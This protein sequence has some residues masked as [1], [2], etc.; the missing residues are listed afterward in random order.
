VASQR[1]VGA[2]HR[3]VAALREAG[4]R[5]RK[6][7][8]PAPALLDRGS[9]GKVKAMAISMFKAHALQVMDKEYSL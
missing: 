1:K 8:F 2:V 7:G 9:R 6:N 5:I 4:A 3:D